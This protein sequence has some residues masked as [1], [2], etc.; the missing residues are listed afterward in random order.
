M[1]GTEEK[2]S[3]FM[4]KAALREKYK[5]IRKEFDHNEIQK[6]SIMIS[7]K[8]IESDV[9][10]SADVIYIYEAFG[11]EINLDIVRDEALNQGKTLLY[12][13]VTGDGI[14]V[15]HCV[16]DKKQLVKGYMGIM[17]P[18]ECLPVYTKS[19]NDK[20]L[21]LVSGTVFDK[22]CGRIGMGKGFYDRYI[23]REDIDCIVGIC[24]EFQIVDSIPMDKNDRYMDMVITEKN[25]YKKA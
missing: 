23:Q 24:S 16:K 17:E 14:M 4:D 21:M 10:K 1:S 6:N 25:I 18:D 3:K 13:R 8:I 19:D 20:T 7:N 5:T 15:F 12:P 2:N 9:Y 22:H 11:N